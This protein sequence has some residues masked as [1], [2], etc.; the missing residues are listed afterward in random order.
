MKTLVGQV[1]ELAISPYE[2]IEQL[3]IRASDIYDVPYQ[4]IRAIYAGKDLMSYKTLQ[5][6]G[7][8]KESTVHF[9]F[10]MRRNNGG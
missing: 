7:I 3:Y 8:H 10:R 1:H 2:T 4:D 6:Y 9:V 5:D